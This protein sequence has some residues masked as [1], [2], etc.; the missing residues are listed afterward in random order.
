MTRARSRR[1]S[2]GLIAPGK[3]SPVGDCVDILRPFRIRFSNSGSYVP[4]HGRSHRKQQVK[5]LRG[6]PRVRAER[7]CVE[8]RVVDVARSVTGL[9]EAGRSRS[10]SRLPGRGRTPFGDQSGHCRTDTQRDGPHERISPAN[11]PRCWVSGWLL[12]TTE[13]PQRGHDLPA[14]CG[15]RRARNERAQLPQATSHLQSVPSRRTANRH[16]ARR[17]DALFEPAASARFLAVIVDLAPVTGPSTQCTRDSVV[18]PPVD[19]R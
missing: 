16:L 4:S 5:G 11:L 12:V 15:R 10:D 3:L 8:V 1:S 6:V 19:T 17:A 2:S 13:P 18:L 7:L 14:R 9:V